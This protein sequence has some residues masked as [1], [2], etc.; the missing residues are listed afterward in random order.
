MYT[1]L[2]LWARIYTVGSRHTF[3]AFSSSL[4]RGSRID[5]SLGGWGRTTGL[6]ESLSSL[7]SCTRYFLTPVQ[8][9]LLEGVGAL[10]AGSGLADSDT[11]G[12]KVEVAIFI[13]TWHH[14]LRTLGV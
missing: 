9:C 10:A 2:N 1:S 8:A 6:E 4:D 12:S 11:V 14:H 3:C 7:S 13:H 5:Y